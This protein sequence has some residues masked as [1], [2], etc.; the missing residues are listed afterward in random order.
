MFVTKLGYL[1]KTSRQSQGEAM[2]AKQYRKKYDLDNPTSRFDRNALLQ[3]LTDEFDARLSSQ[4]KIIWSQWSNLLTD[5]SIK[6]HSIF[7]GTRTTYEDVDKMFSYLFATVIGPRQDALF[8][9]R[10]STQRKKELAAV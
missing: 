4:G 2:N 10:K 5:F 8:G 1:T 3:D 6:M 7:M 9:E